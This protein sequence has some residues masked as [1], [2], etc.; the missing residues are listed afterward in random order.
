D[1]IAGS[2][3]SVGSETPLS[4]GRSYT[5]LDGKTQSKKATS[6]WL[7]EIDLNGR[8]DWYGPAEPQIV[9]GLTPEKSQARMLAMLGRTANRSTFVRSEAESPGKGSPRLKPLSG[10][11][12][13]SFRY[14]LPPQPAV[15][16]SVRQEGW[17]RIN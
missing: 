7:E 5:W 8:S 17:Y 16:I 11:D 9:A 1:L 12:T 2:A 6:Y 15:K 14:D 13:Q 4:A 10:F 3:L